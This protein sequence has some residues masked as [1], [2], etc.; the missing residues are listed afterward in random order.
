M[1][2]LLPPPPRQTAADSIIH[3]LLHSWFSHW[4]VYRLIYHDFS[5]FEELTSVFLILIGESYDRK[6]G[7]NRRLHVI[8]SDIRYIEKKKRFVT[9]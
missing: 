8:V 1:L 5:K 3:W 7:L 9:R 6:H 2:V 4:E